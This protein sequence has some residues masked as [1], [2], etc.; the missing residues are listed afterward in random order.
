MIT[1][2]LEESLKVDQIMSYNAL[3]QVPSGVVVKGDLSSYI[4][5]KIED[6]GTLHIYT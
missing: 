2:K 6:L 1:A 4:D 5:Y 3:L